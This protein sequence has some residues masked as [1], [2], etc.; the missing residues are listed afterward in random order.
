[1]H[2]HVVWVTNI[3]VVDLRDG[4]RVMTV[5]VPCN[6]QVIMSVD[7]G[8]R[9]LGVCIF[10][11]QYKEDNVI[12]CK[13][14]YWERIDCL[15]LIGLSDID[16][17]KS[18]DTACIRMCLDAWKRCVEVFVTHRPDYVV[19]EQQPAERQRKM[20]TIANILM[21]WLMGQFEAKGLSPKIEFINSQLKLNSPFLQALIAKA[22]MQAVVAKQEPDLNKPLDE[23]KDMTD[24]TYAEIRTKGN[25]EYKARK[26]GSIENA[27]LI[28]MECFH[29]GDV[30]TRYM[31]DSK[32]KSDDLA[33][34][35]LQGVAA[36][37][38]FRDIQPKREMHYKD[39][40]AQRHYQIRQMY[41]GAA[42][43]TSVST[44]KTAKKTKPSR[45]RTKASKSD[46]ELIEAWDMGHDLE[47][48]G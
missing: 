48:I 16:V 26:R 5:L 10:R 42:I 24:A 47:C 45:K 30:W 35:L 38:R 4:T 11:V 36:A 8:V 12:K 21:V 37:A 32:G 28:L 34:A 2:V 14:L 6:E 40:I 13:M 44:T 1:M 3:L 46:V 33:D 9:N 17:R 23:T 22:T 29:H 41:P 20:H 43:K 31:H 15:D 18:T 19:I 25:K 27:P 39:P 7:P